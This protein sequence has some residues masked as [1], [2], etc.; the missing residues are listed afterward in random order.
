MILLTANDSPTFG[1]LAGFAV[2]ILAFFTGIALLISV[3]DNERWP[4]QKKK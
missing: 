2:I 4:W 1:T 3:L